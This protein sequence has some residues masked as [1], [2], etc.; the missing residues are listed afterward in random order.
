M[1]SL[2]VVAVVD[3]IFFVARIRETAR[4]TGVP[5]Q[6]VPAAQFGAT[7]AR[8]GSATGVASVIV[9]LGSAGAVDLIRKIKT[10]APTQKLFVLAFASH[11]A[12]GLI[13]A[14]R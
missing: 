2:P 11:V 14:A 3:D 10:N 5:I 1:T 4:Q 7:L 12:T 6:V 13:A 9:D 8:Q